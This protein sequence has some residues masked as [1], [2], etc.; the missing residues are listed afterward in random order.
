MA[1]ATPTRWRWPPE[2]V[3]GNRSA[4]LARE[5]HEIEQLVHAGRNGGAVPPEQLRRDGDV[6]GDGQMREEADLLEHIADAPAQGGGIDRGDVGAEG[7]DG[8][9]GRIDQTV[10]GLQQGGL[11]RPGFADDDD[12]LAGP[13]VERDVANGVA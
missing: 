8:A 10:D 2:S 1:R 12:E 7:P 5:T 11:A 13:N 6:L 3:S 4:E 9:G